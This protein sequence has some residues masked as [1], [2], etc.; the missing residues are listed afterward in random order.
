[1]K[2]PLIQFERVDVVLNGHT[3]LR[4][5]DWQLGLGEHWA[6][7]G[8]NG[9]GKSTLLK[10]VRGELWPA[11][12]R[13]R[14]VYAFDGAEQ[15]SAVGIKERIGMVSPELQDRYL[16]QDWVL[17]GLQVIQTGFW[18][19]DYLYQKPT[20][21]QKAEALSISRLLRI[22]PLLARN[23][24]QLSTGELRKILIA[25]ALVG[26]PRI[27]ICDEICDGLD[28]RSREELLQTI[29][30]IARNGTQV[31]YSTHRVA[32][33]IP[34]LTHELILEQGQIVSCCEKSCADAA[35][36]R[37]TPAQRDRSASA[38]SRGT[39]TVFS[40]ADQTTAPVRRPIICIKRA[41]V[42]LNR[43]RVLRDINWELQADQHWAILGANGAGK[44]TL[45]KLI[46][47]D[48]HPALG[49]VVERFA[50]S[51]NSTI[52]EVKNRIGYV[53]PDFQANYRD[54]LTGSEVIASGFFSSVGLMKSTLSRQK[55]KVGQLLGS[56]GLE[57]LTKKPILQMSYGE[58][59]A[60]LI[61]RA[62]VNEPQV[63]LLDEP[64]DG[65]DLSAKS[66]IGKALEKLAGNGTSLIIVTHHPVDL[67]ACITHG[68]LLEKGQI[69]CQ[70]Q[71]QQIRSHP[72]V[73]RSQLT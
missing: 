53:S 19:T 48:L 64:F 44:S 50:L 29:E 10:L 55:T 54:T 14:R 36:T 1:M 24:Q 67:P 31:L 33:I 5:L 21:K 9:S 58:F 47:G 16:E 25:R 40:N 3:I 20:P 60:V 70:G 56:L 59:R 35:P 72:A 7:R 45:L 17:T 18:N 46:F 43:K 49:G 32:E 28:G 41:N 23:V 65:L 12:G 38:R 69:L 30:R 42:F 51:V 68:L 22:E 26:R 57:S 13:G 2:K 6:I 11:P 62:L 34:A 39:S 61:L 8:R 63:L 37:P 71:L 66:D 27:L 73:E 52:W 4:D 15:T